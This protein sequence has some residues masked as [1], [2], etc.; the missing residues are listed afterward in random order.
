[1]LFLPTERG[2]V[3]S[4]DGR[5]VLR[6]WID[7][8]MASEP[9]DLELV[10][11]KRELDARSSLVPQLPALGMHALHSAPE[12]AAWGNARPY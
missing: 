9:R 7:R 6:G 12:P 4:T 3:S 8:V 2:L 1:M 5:A 10:V 11:P